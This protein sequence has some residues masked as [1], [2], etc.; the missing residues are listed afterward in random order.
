M[1]T[2]LTDPL[3]A[4]RVIG[5]MIARAQGLGLTIRTSSDFKEFAALRATV[6]DCQVSPMFDR[7]VSLLD[8][9]R[10]FWMG[11]FDAT[12]NVK[13]L[14]AFRLDIVF[15]S[16]AEWALGWMAGLYI[17][18]HELVLPAAIEPP[19]HSRSRVL[20]GNLVYHG[21]MWIESS[22][23]RREW[24]GTF[25]KLGMLVTYLK[26]SPDALWALIGNTV[27][28]HGYI[29]RSGYAMQE[30]S[31]LQWQT[32]WEPHGADQSEWLVIAEHSHLEFLIA[33]ELIRL[34]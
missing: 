6:R 18:R 17:K 10:S 11:A 28:T 15:P 29:A 27:A 3:G 21:E 30:H 34:S 8:E 25:L 7:T 16:L 32:E 23:H 9:S 31:F 24:F 13:S 12:G 33:E 14:Q 19:Q 26:W 22:P 5:D 1:H 20:K 2:G 4:V